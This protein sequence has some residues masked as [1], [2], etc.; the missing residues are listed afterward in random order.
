[1]FVNNLAD[2]YYYTAQLGVRGA[3]GDPRMVGVRLSFNY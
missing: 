1:V 2:A 3:V